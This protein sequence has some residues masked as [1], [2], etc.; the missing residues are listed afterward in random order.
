MKVLEKKMF[1]KERSSGDLVEV[2]TLKDLFDP[3][4]VELVV[5]NQKGEE[6]QDPERIKKAELVFPSGEELPKCW[7]DTHYR[8]K[9]NK[10]G[11]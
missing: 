7:I 11:K 5:R 2:L 6:V 1:L 9:A 8:D 3:F 4:Q 10:L